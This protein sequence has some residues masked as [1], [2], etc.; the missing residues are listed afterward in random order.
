M[1]SEALSK[2]F[3]HVPRSAAKRHL[4]SEA[5]RAIADRKAIRIKPFVEQLRSQGTTSPHRIALALQRMKVPTPDG[6]FHWTSTQVAR[7]LRRLDA[8]NPSA[9]T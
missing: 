4:A 9:N 8:G 6:K 3:H 2:L 1:T 7:L 5:K